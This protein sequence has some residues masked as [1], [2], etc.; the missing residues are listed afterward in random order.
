MADNLLAGIKVLVTR[1]K[2]QALGL[3]RLI[4]QA[5]GEAILFPTLEIK[6]Y[7]FDKHMHELIQQL[8][9]AAFIIFLSANAVAVVADWIT[10]RWPII[11][12]QTK[13][14]AIGNGT[15]KALLEHKLPVALTPD[16]DAS[17]EGLLLLPELQDL[18]GKNI[19]IF[20]GEGGRGLLAPGL[21][22]RGAKVKEINV[23]QR[24]CP[25]INKELE[26]KRLQA[27]GI[28]VI[29]ITSGE[30]LENLF[31]LLPAPQWL[32]GI[33]FIG[34]SQRIAKLAEQLG[35]KR[36]VIA[37]NASDEAMLNAIGHAITNYQ[38]P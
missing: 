22:E 20:K 14:I 3:C 8:D 6:P 32:A 13:I 19:W 27:K 11:P 29:V 34:L 15:R 2:E 36:I 28:N 7:P 21:A 25:V 30:N 35:I 12:E 10:R 23:Y 37:D 38:V 16:A 5:G 4:E 33:T 17:T 31:R 1:P 26:L 18:A 24:Q 9:Q